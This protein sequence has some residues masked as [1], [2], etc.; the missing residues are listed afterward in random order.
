MVFCGT[1]MR[2]ASS[3]AGTPSG[4]RLTNS[5]NVSRRV[6]WASADKAAM[7]SRL[8]IYPELQIFMTVARHGTAL[9]SKGT[10]LAGFYSVFDSPHRAAVVEPPHQPVGQLAE[11]LGND[12]DAGD[13]HYV[14]HQC[15]GRDAHVSRRIG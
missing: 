14:L 7:V 13:D 10:P 6:D 15:L 9:K 8:S 2:R 4:S 5:R 11:G 3:P 1:S 12:F